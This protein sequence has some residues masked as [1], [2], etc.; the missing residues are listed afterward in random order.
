MKKLSYILVAALALFAVACNPEEGGGGDSTVTLSLFP[1]TLSFEADAASAQTFTVSATGNWT[2]SATDSW[3]HYS[4]TTGSVNGTVSVTVDKNESEARGGKISVAC[5]NLTK[6][7]FVSQKRGQTPAVDVSV[8]PATFDGVK[9][10]S[11]T[12]QLLVYS[13]ADG[14]GNDEIGDFKGVQ[15]KIEEGYFDDLG[16]SAIWLSPAHPTNSYHG[17]DVNDYF[18]LNPLFGTEGDFK[19][20]IDAAHAKGI[21][22]YMDYVLNHSGT[23]TEWFKSV[24]ADPKNSPYRDYYVLSNGDYPS[25]AIG[26]MGGWVSLGDGEIGY[27]GRLHFKVDWTETTKYVTVTETT[28][29]A[30]SPNTSDAKRWIHIGSKGSLGMYETATNIF[31][32]TL[33]V[34]TD[35]GF[36][37]RTSNSDSWPSGTKYGGM[38]GKNVITL[39]QPFPLDNTTAADI[40]FGECTS[41]YASFDASMP[42]LNYGN[43]DECENSRAFQSTVES[44]KK[45]VNLGVDGFRLDAVVWIYGASVTANVKFLDKWYKEVNAAYK[46]AGHSDDIFMVGEA[47]HN[48]HG[49]EQKYYGGLPSNFEFDYWGQAL[50]PAVNS[51]QGSSYASKVINYIS[52]HEANRT[53]APMAITS[54]FMTNHDKS[55]VK[56]II[57]P[58]NSKEEL[59]F[60]RAADDLG[61][62]LAKEKQ[63]CAMLLTTAGKPFIYQGE[64]LGYWRGLDDKNHLDDEYIRAPIVWDAS[65]TKVA[66]KGVNNKVD[67]DMLKGSISVETQSK[68]EASL[69]NTYMTWNRLRNTFDALASG[70]MSKTGISGSSIASW[71]MT[72]GSQ[73]MLVI[74]NVAAGS[75]TVTVTDKM[76]T[77][78][79]L[80]GTATIKDNKLTLG[81]NSSVVFEL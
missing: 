20:L 66:K 63:A 19:N 64:E 50:Q 47:W 69:L 18:A 5:G 76:D 4:P 31:E 37:V 11:T 39:G 8:I 14:I 51:G 16:V 46:A 52:N 78:R 10:A 22:I 33:D 1:T 55:S 74:H 72:S 49:E 80:L 79:A 73:K 30:Q 24:K 32:L 71:Y 59:H 2:V 6:D 65:A 17:Y 42:D 53:D 21:K 45:W 60:Y 35:W 25:E 57:N 9:R 68:D 44:A 67:G 13:F 58:Y 56:F 48:G 36:L 75:T 15:N 77:P 29:A 7:V 38:A 28:E 40:V 61:K 23:G 3:I 43:P 54:F 26:G 70:T 62:D 41:Y 81:A 12:Y 27:K 34:D